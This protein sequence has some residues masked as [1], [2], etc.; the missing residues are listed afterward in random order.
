ME[1]DSVVA[2][3]SKKTKENGTAHGKET[4]LISLNHCYIGMKVGHITSKSTRKLENI[5]GHQHQACCSYLIELTTLF[6]LV[7]SCI[8]KS[9]CC[10]VMARCHI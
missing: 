9:T 1:I 8:H 6:S 2:S 7:S 10:N 5:S 4:K 3:Q